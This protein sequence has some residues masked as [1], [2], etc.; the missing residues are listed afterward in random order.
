LAV[1]TAAF[2]SAVPLSIRKAWDNETVFT[3][4]VV[5]LRS[6]PSLL[7]SSRHCFFADRA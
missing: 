5:G 2:S 7:S 3:V 1:A 6:C 4:V